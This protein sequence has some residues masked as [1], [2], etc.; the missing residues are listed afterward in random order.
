MNLI[1]NVDLEDKHFEGV[2]PGELF[3]NCITAEGQ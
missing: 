1:V 3:Y 2:D